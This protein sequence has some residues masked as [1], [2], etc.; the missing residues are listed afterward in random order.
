MLGDL[1]DTP[2]DLMDQ[3]DLTELSSEVLRLARVIKY[4]SYPLGT[5]F[6]IMPGEEGWN[7]FA[8]IPDNK[9]MWMMFVKSCYR[10]E[11]GLDGLDAVRWTQEQEREKDD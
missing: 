3:Q 10:S 6:T 11:I 1:M 5:C 8:S 4:A 9:H 7:R 2:V